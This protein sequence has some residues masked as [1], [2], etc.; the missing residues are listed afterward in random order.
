MGLISNKIYQSAKENCN[1][2]YIDFDPHNTMS[3]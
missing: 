1:G 2:N 3:K